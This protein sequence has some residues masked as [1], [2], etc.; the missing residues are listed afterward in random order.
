MTCQNELGCVIGRMYTLHPNQGDVYYM[1]LLLLHIRG[2]T[3]F[4][5][6][7]TVDGMLCETFKDACARLNLLNNDDEWRDCLTEAS[8]CQMAPRLRQLFVTLLVFCE[9]ADPLSLFDQFSDNLAEDIAYQLKKKSKNGTETASHNKLLLMLQK[10]LAVHG[11]SLTD[12]KLP[13]RKPTCALTTSL[14]TNETPMP[15]T[16]THNISLY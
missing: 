9:P 15:P 4:L 13:S 10:M 8:T 11:R 16:S 5:E 12:F 3:S 2:P 1:R 7:R 6:L 14:R